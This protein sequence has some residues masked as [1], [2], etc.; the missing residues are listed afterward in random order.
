[1][2]PSP[3]TV[4][5]TSN[6][7]FRQLSASLNYF[8]FVKVCPIMTFML[9]IFTFYPFALRIMEDDCWSSS[10]ALRYYYFDIRSYA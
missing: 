2:L 7:S 9:P 6:D 4:L 3:L 10:I 8:S 1:M 5:K